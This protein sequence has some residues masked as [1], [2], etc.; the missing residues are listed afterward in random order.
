MA[1]VLGAAAMVY[2]S[3]DVVRTVVVVAVVFADEDCSNEGQR[4]SKIL[5]HNDVQ[6][7]P[8]NSQQHVTQRTISSNLHST[9]ATI[10]LYYMWSIMY[11]IASQQ[12]HDKQTK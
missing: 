8:T 9:V 11:R 7:Q 12:L 5:L 4:S 1:V 2:R 6:N 3:Q 10:V